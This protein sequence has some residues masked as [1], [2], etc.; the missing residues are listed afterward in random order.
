MRDKLPNFAGKQN[1]GNSED[2]NNHKNKNSNTES[3]S[4]KNATKQTKCGHDAANLEDLAQLLK[5]HAHQ[6]HEMWQSMNSN[7]LAHYLRQ[8][9]VLSTR[10]VHKGVL[11]GSDIDGGV[12]GE[13][14]VVG[15][16]LS[17]IFAL[18]PASVWDTIPPASV[19]LGAYKEQI[20]VHGDDITTYSWQE[21]SD[22]I[23]AL[24]IEIPNMIY[25]VEE[26]DQGTDSVDSVNMAYACDADILHLSI[27]LMAQIGF[28]INNAI[29]HADINHQQDPSIEHMQSYTL[30]T[31]PTEDTT[32]KA[33][34]KTCS[35]EGDSSENIDIKF[36]YVREESISVQITAMHHIL[37][38]LLATTTAVLVP[39]DLSVE[40]YGHHREAS[41]DSFYEMSML[42]DLA[43][44]FVM[45]YRN[46]FAHLFHSISQVVYFHYPQYIRK[47]QISLQHIT[48]PNSSHISVLPL[49]LQIRPDIPVFYEHTGALCNHIHDKYDWSWIMLSGY[50][51]L[52]HR[53]GNTYAA[54][55]LRS[56]LTFTT[57]TELP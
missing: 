31:Q 51:L 56:L 26:S 17:S 33:D 4:D 29:L 55:D 38:L 6:N 32:T 49:L 20:L 40:L 57:Q 12:K 27:H 5:S 48:K 45:Q 2:V 3:D 36:V 37:S 53:S 47:K 21:I 23:T 22:T 39:E 30:H 15:N 44:G 41:I 16:A 50:V 8:W 46:K 9:I 24:Q 43:P 18:L 35:T 7:K 13:V 10:A 14:Y 52:R 25:P 11:V 28:Y 54:R 42:A 34:H 1:N 19:T